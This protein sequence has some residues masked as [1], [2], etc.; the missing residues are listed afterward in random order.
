MLR[1]LP[2][3][4]Q[5]RLQ[6]STATAR[7]SYAVAVYLFAPIARGG[8]RSRSRPQWVRPRW[9]ANV[10]R[11]TGEFLAHSPASVREIYWARSWRASCPATDDAG[12]FGSYSLVVN[13]RSDRR[14]GAVL[15]HHGVDRDDVL[16]HPAVPAAH[17]SLV[18]RLSARGAFD[19]G[20]A[21]G[22]GLITLPLIAIAYGQ[23]TGTLLGNG[24]A[25]PWLFGAGVAG[26]RDQP[27]TGRALGD[28][29]P[30]A[31]R[32]PVAAQASSSASTDSGMSKLA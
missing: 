13:L 5:Q 28:A 32:R 25:S 16:D 27:D 18:L 7:T 4:A 24:A 1:I 20:G 10:E 22:L 29:Q 23:A 14:P 12:G 3:A 31:R 11:G 19:R 30:P 6:G 17:L 15:P 21:A 26:R 2:E 9:S 8:C